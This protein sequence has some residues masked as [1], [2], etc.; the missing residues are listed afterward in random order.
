MSTQQVC[1]AEHGDRLA[2]R[3]VIVC[4]KENRDALTVSRDLKALM[5]IGRLI[6]EL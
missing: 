6:H 3:V 2:E 4:T 1:V 5:G